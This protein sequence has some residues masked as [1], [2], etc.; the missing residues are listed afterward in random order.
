MVVG[1]NCCSQ[2]EGKFRKGPVS[3]LNHDTGTCIKMNLMKHPHNDDM[4]SVS[5][6]YYKA[7]YDIGSC[8]HGSYSTAA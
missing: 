4:G 8:D 2:N 7:L 3:T 5:S 1:P 6:T